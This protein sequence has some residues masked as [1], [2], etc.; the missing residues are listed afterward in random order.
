MK[1]YELDLSKYEDIDVFREGVCWVKSGGKWGLI[2]STGE[3]IIKPQYEDIRE[4]NEGFGCFKKSGKWGLVDKLG[5]EV[6]GPTFS[7]ILMIREGMALIKVNDRY[8]F[9]DLT[10]RNIIEPVYEKAHVFSEGLAAVKINGKWG[11]IDKTGRMAIKPE[12]YLIP[13][14]FTFK[15]DGTIFVHKNGPGD[16]ELEGYID[17]G[18]NQIGEWDEV[19]W[20][21]YDSEWSYELDPWIDQG[22]RTYWGL[23]DHVGN[24]VIKPKFQEMRPAVEGSFFVKIDDKWGLIDSRGNYLIEP[25]YDD[26]DDVGENRIRV[27]ENGRYGFADLSGR[28]L[29][30]P[31]YRHTRLSSFEDGL[32]EICDDNSKYGFMD[33]EG[34]IVINP[35]FDFVA[36]F[37]DGM[38]IAEIN[39]KRGIIDK[40]GDFLVKPIY[41]A[42]ENGFSCDR[43]LVRNE[44]KYGF[45]DRSGDLIIGTQYEDA[46]GF[47]NG[48]ARVEIDD[49]WGLIDIEGNWKIEP[50]FEDIDEMMIGGKLLY[51]VRYNGKSGIIDS[52]G[53]YLI[54]PL[55][56]RIIWNENEGIFTVSFGESDDWLGSLLNEK[57]PS[58][59]LIDQNG[60]WI[61][62]EGKD[63]EEFQITGGR[64]EFSEGLAAVKINEKWGYI[65]VDGKVV[66]QPLF[67]DAS[68][69]EEGL[70]IVRTDGKYGV[71]NRKGEFIT[72]ERFENISSH[73]KN[74]YIRVSVKHNYEYKWGVIDK[75]G[76]YALAPK[77]DYVFGNCNEGMAQISEKELF[78]YADLE[79][80]NIINPVFNYAFEFTNG[81]AIVRVTESQIE[82]G[83]L[84]REIPK[85]KAAST[86]SQECRQLSF[87]FDG[88][89]E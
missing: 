11:F 80:G 56:N 50:K 36:A 28:Y 29:L 81:L 14:F 34:N 4:F 57:E 26:I 85:P 70:A 10:T 58:W 21:N 89:E 30:K 12:F 40:H 22:I 43:A 51:Q 86:P 44:G 60:K 65:G 31:L 35:R 47:R 88:D 66:I 1:T 59:G 24:Y 53:K 49:K 54:E 13:P 17:R 48:L 71:I 8:G 62:R 37:H 15:P 16:Q 79:T 45:V 41:D 75:S 33:L 63:T 83:I 9:A 39:G 73:I 87:D 6:F 55:Y 32:I 27:W 72:K 61:R 42:I 67:E 2:N 76:K 69:F 68:N 3:V 74:G 84:N 20:E 5:N 18:G 46:Y 77:F 19:E 23:I 64:I 78:G 52:S 38:T 7:R 25:S 82:D